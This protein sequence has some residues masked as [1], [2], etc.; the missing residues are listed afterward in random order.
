MARKLFFKITRPRI[1]MEVT[2]PQPIA[3]AT[4][5]PAQNGSIWARCWHYLSIKAWGSLPEARQRNISA[6]YAKIYDQPWSRHLIAPYCWWHY[7]E[8]DYIRHFKPAGGLGTFRTFQD[9]FTR[10]FK[11]L[12]KVDSPQ[13]WPC[14]GVLCHSGKVAEIPSSIVKGDRRSVAD[15]F[16]LAP[17]EI[18][19][20][21]QFSNVFLHNKNYHRIHAPITSTIRR[22]QHIPDG[23]VI[24]RPWIYPYN[25][26][27]PAF[28]NE[29]VNIDL[30][31][32]QGRL[33]YLSIVG[34]PAV[35][36]IELN[37]AVQLGAK[38]DILNEIAVFY[39]GSTCCMAAPEGISKHPDYSEVW[40]GLSY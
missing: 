36:S 30:E 9:F 12:P 26:S 8:R 3:E 6:A 32:E 4:S 37:A 27:V 7:P 18:P 16:G 13:V 19:A 25:P 22:I 40:L 34:G 15:I 33:W 5:R 2:V 39:L 24:L 21:Y 35:G 17:N 29:R 20:D 28:R 10:Q 23:L 31:D 1:K 11:N 14:E 38:L